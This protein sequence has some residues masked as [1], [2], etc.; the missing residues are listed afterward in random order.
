[1]KKFTN[2]LLLSD[3]DGTL[4]NSKGVISKKN[5]EA[6]QYFI[7]NGGLF[8][9]AT[10]RSQLNSVLFLDE[11]KVN[12]PCILYNGGGVYDF[13]VNRFI[14]LQELSKVRLKVFLEDCLVQFPEVAIQIYCPDMCYIVS[15]ESQA[16]PYF[17][18]IHQPCKFCTID[19]IA[20]LPWIKILFCGKTEDLNV[21]NDGMI[22]FGLEKELN[23]VFSSE[24]Y[25]EYLPYGVNK[26]SALLHMKELLNSDYKVYAVG[27][28]N[29]DVEMLQVADVGIATKNA[30]SSLKE[31]ADVVT[32]SNDEDAIADIINNIL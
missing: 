31:L 29:N 26:G 5:Q 24:I 12:A 9:I 8:G 25:L 19:E 27:D 32:V 7:E 13:A 4:L 17:I 23:W 21:L 30:L 14:L 11:I 6:V 22:A 1:M 28:Y 16:D 20:D 3:M 10:G 2:K 15:Q 18:S